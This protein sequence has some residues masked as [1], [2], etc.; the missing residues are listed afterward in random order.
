MADGQTDRNIDQQTDWQTHIVAYTAAIAAKN[1]S[2]G[3]RKVSE[4]KANCQNNNFGKVFSFHTF[5]VFLTVSFLGFVD[6]AVICISPLSKKMLLLLS[7]FETL[8]ESKLQI[9]SR[10]K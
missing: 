5:Q 1:D 7:I 6:A 3:P 9:F 10:H 8:F 2:T 4:A